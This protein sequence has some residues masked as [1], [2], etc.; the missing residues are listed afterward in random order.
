MPRRRFWNILRTILAWGVGIVF[1]Y[2]SVLKI[3]DPADFA[4]NLKYYK[5][6][7]LWAINATALL[8][9]W[10]E[11]SAGLALFFS[12]WRRAGAAIVFVLT[13]G[14]IGAVTSAIIRGLDISCGCFGVYSN[15]VGYQLL[16]FDV[17]L[18]LATGYVF[19]SAKRRREPPLGD[20]AR[21]AGPPEASAV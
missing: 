13:C 1:I 2:A 14:F 20:A 18:L 16:A 12:G 19:L 17:C 5:L 9:P 21:A 11:L 6:L 7:P 4:Q 10:W 15:R 8:L 3:A